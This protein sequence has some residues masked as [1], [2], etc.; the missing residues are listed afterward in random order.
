MINKT[1]MFQFVNTYISNLVY[2]FYYQS[3]YKLQLNLI[4]VMV[5][6]QVLI[7]TIEYL[8]LKFNVSRKIK[9]V[10]KL[11]SDRKNALAIDDETRSKDKIIEL[12]D[13]RMHRTIEKQN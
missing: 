1:Y 10:E 7:N 12:A 5:F 8:S 11:F 4:T 3:F 9:K 2:I 6:K 13:L